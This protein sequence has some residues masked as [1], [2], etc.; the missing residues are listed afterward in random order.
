MELRQIIE[1]LS[2]PGAYPY[3]VERVEVRQTHISVVFLAGDRAFKVKKPVTFPFLDYGTP[4]L[5]RHYCEEEVRLN[6]R[7][8][9]D[10]YLG[11]VPV[12]ERGGR[13]S[14]GGEGEV[15]EHAV[16][17]LR[18]PDE[19]SL[20]ELVRA[21]RIDR[22]LIEEA[23]RRIAGFH[24]RAERF[25]ADFDAV[26]RNVRENLEVG[27][28][29]FRGRLS[30]RIESELERLR[31]LLERRPACDAHG[32]L[33]LEHVYHFPGRAPPGDWIAIDGIE[34]NERFRR[35]DPVADMAFLHMDLIAH[36][37]RDLAG[38]FADAYFRASG[39]DEG[40]ALLDFY[41]SYRAAVRGKVQGLRSLG[42]E[43]PA[44]ERERARRRAR[45]FWLLA[46]SELEP[47]ERKPCLALVAGLPGTG[48]TTLARALAAEAGFEVVRSD[49]VRKERVVAGGLYTPERTRDTYAEC[50]R[51][52][53]EILAGGGRA[54]VDAS[55]RSGEQRLGFVRAARDWAVPLVILH[56]TA[57]PEAARERLAARQGDASDADWAV[58]LEMAR[59]W[60][61]LGPA[62]REID[63]SGT[64]AS[65]VSQALS[66][67]R[68]AGLL[69]AAPASK[70][71]VIV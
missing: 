63:A 31:P 32:D 43:V 41:T 54:L 17:M 28:P 12:T 1:G 37:R 7:W 48:K 57:P 58:Y 29:A 38:A 8:A 39:D 20:R 52:A 59:T 11:V 47:P 68:D 67:L 13:L 33:R 65:A 45:A 22:A 64:P 3:P 16:E 10:V 21:G 61:D 27:R 44:D 53:E 35:V 66:A 70:R 14:F 30:A 40:R 46:L 19:V 18:L 71:R 55:F 60:E 25:P 51:R 5:R 9:P 34:F 23:G 42:E 2:R 26:A 4:E 56:C 49:V 6:R 15:V 62:A 50:L 24:A 69:Q 36:E